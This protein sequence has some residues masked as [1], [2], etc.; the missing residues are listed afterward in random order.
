M[1]KDKKEE[2]KMKYVIWVV[3][4]EKHEGSVE[5]EAENPE[6]AKLMAE[7]LDPKDMVVG[8]DYRVEVE[9]SLVAWAWQETGLEMDGDIIPF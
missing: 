8:D 9:G 3:R 4:T 5:L 2:T 6:Q 7:Q 1:W